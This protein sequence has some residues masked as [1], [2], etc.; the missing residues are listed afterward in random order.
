VGWVIGHLARTIFTPL[1]KT[2]GVENFRYDI[3]GLRAWAVVAVVFHHFSISGFQGGFVGVDVFFVISGFLMTHLIVQG[4]AKDCGGRGFSLWRFYLARAR[5]IVPALVVLCVTLVVGGWFFLS[6][7]IY[8]QL[9]QHT[10]MALGFVSNLQFWSEADYFDIV[11]REKW[12]LHTWSL[13]VEWQFY[14]LLPLVLMVLWRW[15]PGMRS[16]M[17][18]LTAGFGSSLILSMIMTPIRPVASFYLLPTRAWEML[19]GGLVFTLAEQIKLSPA[20]RRG[21]EGAGFALIV[22][23]IHLMRPSSAWPGWLALFPVMGTVL[24]LSAARSNSLWTGTSVAQYLGK[25]SY[26]IYLWH[27]PVMVILMYVDI[28]TAPL[29]IGIG[30]LGSLCLGHLSWFCVERFSRRHLGVLDWGYGFVTLAIM[31]GVVATLGRVIYLK[32]GL[33]SRLDPSIAAIFAEANNKNPQIAECYRGAP[34]SPVECTYGGHQLGAIVIGDSHAASIVRTVQEAMNTPEKHVLDWTYST[35]PT[36]ANVHMV[37]PQYGDHCGQFINNAL[38]RQKSMDKVPLF[39]VN[40]TSLYI[41]GH[42]EMGK[43]KDFGRV[44]IYFDT[45]YDTLTL[46][47]LS[48]FR[49]ILIE[50][51]CQFANVRPVYILRPIPELRRNVPLTMGRAAMFGSQKRVSISLEEYHERHRTVWKIQDAAQAQCGV[52][53]LDPLPY[54]CWEGRCWGDKDGV[55]IYFD[56]D[57]L[58]ERGAALLMPLFKAGFQHT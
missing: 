33:S 32:D 53:I 13:S 28:L 19:A 5:R 7:I 43:E 41:K 58:N 30:I 29:A 56:D 22:G 27:W 44:A 11:S 48:S 50:T 35:C 14:I 54:L 21:V 49:R 9:G 25:V 6:D 47:L 34:S 18:G 46:N 12:L 52:H 40:R 2:S 36:L 31:V 57:H 16:V 1:D 45:R 39:I 42:N 38:A 3:N 17:Y 4:L 8:R 55:P 15:R 10:T 23:S 24:V 26:S 51:A 20:Q 37:D